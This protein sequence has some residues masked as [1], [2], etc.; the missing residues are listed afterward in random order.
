MNSVV[1]QQ[2]C[3]GLSSVAVAGVSAPQAVPSGSAGNAKALFS[4]SIQMTVTSPLAW[5]CDTQGPVF[6]GI[7]V[8]P[9]FK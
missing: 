1:I 9:N 6:K 4:S 3:N 8:T 7:Q 5:T 2:D